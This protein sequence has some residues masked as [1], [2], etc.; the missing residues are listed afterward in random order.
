M[1]K[2]KAR[3][4]GGK[5]WTA[6]GA[7]RFAREAR[8][9]TVLHLAK[10]QAPVQWQVYGLSAAFDM[11]RR[12]YG[13]RRVAAEMLLGP[14][15]YPPPYTGTIT[16]YAGTALAI[17]TAARAGTSRRPACHPATA[18]TRRRPGSPAPA[19][20]LERPLDRIGMLIRTDLEASRA[21]RFVT[22]SYGQFSVATSVRRVERPR[23][24]ARP[25]QPVATA[26]LIRNATLP[27]SS[28]T[29]IGP[30]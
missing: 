11:W 21:L 16:D 23:V 4:G 25:M 3:A 18:G 5:P 29:T 22:E 26:K 19:G 24:A 9:Q 20:A 14:I 10:A 8:A 27:A 15:G 30:R 12:M 17:A 6:A 1:S 7:A 13:S 28:G 2:A